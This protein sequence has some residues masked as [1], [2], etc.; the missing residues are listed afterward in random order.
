MV[1]VCG[2]ERVSSW[3]VGLGSSDW[4]GCAA[5]QLPALCCHVLAVAAADEKPAG[6]SA[7]RM[8]AW[9][10]FVG[11]GGRFETATV[12]GGHMDIMAPMQGPKGPPPPLF[13]LCLSGLREQ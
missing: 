2:G 10:A 12:P 1:M 4:D 13:D 5:Q 9:A 11:S 3:Q 7:E 6:E 8:K